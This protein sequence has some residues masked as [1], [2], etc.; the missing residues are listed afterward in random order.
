MFQKFLLFAGL[1]IAL[2]Q[3][4]IK[5]ERLFTKHDAER[6]MGETMRLT[7]STVNNT[8]V[9]VSWLRGYQA[10]A[11]V[12]TGRPGAIYM[13]FE[14]YRN[15]AEA[16]KKYKD[17]HEANKPNGIEDLAGLGNEAYYQTDRQGFYFIMVRK[18]KYVFN[19]KVNKITRTTSLQ[20]FKKTARNITA[21]L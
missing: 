15:E 17:I 5:P 4:T 1:L 19:I 14:Q 20:E 9:A 13:L 10:V 18:G 2:M 11:P 16:V 8:A 21:K 6:I 7:D 12:K 3:G